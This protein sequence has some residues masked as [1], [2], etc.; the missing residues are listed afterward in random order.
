MAGHEEELLRRLTAADEVSI[1]NVLALGPARAPTNFEAALTPRTRTLV[2]LAA[3]LALD[4]CT[5]SLRWATELAAC[6]GAC[7]AEIVGVLV[8]VGAEIGAAQLVLSAPRL[9]LAIDY[10][11]DVEGWD[12]T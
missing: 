4:A 10:E 12:G 9:A 7:D 1:R 3:L 11:I 6:A 2:R 5:H 8:A